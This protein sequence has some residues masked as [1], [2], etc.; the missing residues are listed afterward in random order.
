MNSPTGP[1]RINFGILMPAMR[2]GSFSFFAI[3]VLRDLSR[4]TS[5]ADVRFRDGL[6]RKEKLSQRAQNSPRKIPKERQDSLSSAARTHVY[7][8]LRTPP[9]VFPTRLVFPTSL[10]VV[11]ADLV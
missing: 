11:T 3:D 7:L 9:I 4:A 2:F 6:R 10:W 1:L 8:C 5:G